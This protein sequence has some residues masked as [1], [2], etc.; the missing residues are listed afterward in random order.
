MLIGTLVLRLAGRTDPQD[1]KIP[2]QSYGY[3]TSPTLPAPQFAN[4]V[5][6][7]K[8][9]GSILIKPEPSSGFLLW[10]VFLAPI[11]FHPRASALD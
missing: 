3:E 4:G 7:G 2:E 9:R 11:D 5:P 10:A 1:T 8:P 6:S